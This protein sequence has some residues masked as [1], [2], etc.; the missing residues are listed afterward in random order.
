MK[1][2]GVNNYTTVRDYTIV[3]ILI[4]PKS[5]GHRP[6]LSLISSPFVSNLFAVSMSK[7]LDLI[8]DNSL[9]FDLTLTTW[10]ASYLKQWKSFRKLDCI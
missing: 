6:N 1:R 3:L 4:Q 10:A 2:R 7:Y 9:S 5:Q 8:F